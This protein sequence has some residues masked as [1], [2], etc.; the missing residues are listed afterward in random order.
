LTGCAHS[1]PPSPPPTPTPPL[2][3]KLAADCAALV[4]PGELNYDAWQEWVQNTV[5]RSY[6]DCAARHHATVQAWPK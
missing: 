5:L 4:S 2:D 6:G 1:L 3:S